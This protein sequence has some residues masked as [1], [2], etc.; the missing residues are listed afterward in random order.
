LGKFRNDHVAQDS[1]DRITKI[2]LSVKLA[3]EIRRKHGCKLP[4]GG[5]GAP[6]IVTMFYA[7]S[8]EFA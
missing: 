1:T 3:G 6:N 5:A 7:T 4:A 2:R 8:P